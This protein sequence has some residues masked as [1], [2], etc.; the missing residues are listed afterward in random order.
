MVW[1]CMAADGTGSLVFIGDVTADK[2]IKMKRGYLSTAK[3][4][5]CYP[6]GGSNVL[7]LGLF[8]D[9]TTSNK[10]SNE[11]KQVIELIHFL[12]SNNHGVLL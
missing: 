3:W 1:A 5:Y 7:H 4:Y 9:T 12:P 6:L 11:P 8:T 2:S 10:Q